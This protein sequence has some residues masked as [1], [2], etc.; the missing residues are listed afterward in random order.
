MGEAVQDVV[1]VFVGARQQAQ[2]EQRAHAVAPAGVQ[3]VKGVAAARAGLLRAADDLPQRTHLIMSHR[4]SLISLDQRCLDR[5]KRCFISPVG[6]AAVSDNVKQE[7]Q[8][9]IKRRM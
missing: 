6:I 7:S 8:S 4:S 5:R 2:A 9:W 3:R 1:G